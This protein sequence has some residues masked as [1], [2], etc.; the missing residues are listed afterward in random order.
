MKPIKEVFRWEDP[1]T[2]KQ[3]LSATRWAK[4]AAQLREKPGAWA[5]VVEG[6]DTG[7]GG[8]IARVAAFQPRTDWEVTDRTMDDGTHS[9]YIRF[10]GEPRI[11]AND[12]PEMENS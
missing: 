8:N 7:K 12:L 6:A 11:R 4:V 3:N 9:T 1:S 2:T 5:I 10:V